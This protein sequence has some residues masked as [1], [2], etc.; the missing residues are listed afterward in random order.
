MNISYLYSIY[1][2]NPYIF[3][4][5]RKQDR[6]KKGIFFAIQGDNFNG[7]KFALE[8]INGE[9]PLRKSLE[10]N[11]GIFYFYAGL[12]SDIEEGIEKAKEVINSGEALKH[13]KKLIKWRKENID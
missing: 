9:G 11:A 10:W 13:L 3:I 12:S 6:S 7:N 8:A 1:K 5:T 4:D 2:K